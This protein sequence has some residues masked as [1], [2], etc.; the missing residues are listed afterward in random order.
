MRTALSLSSL[1]VTGCFLAP[2]HGNADEPQLTQEESS[3]EPHCVLSPEHWPIDSTPEFEGV[4]WQREVLEAPILVFGEIH[5]TRE[6][7]AFV[8]SYVA[9]YQE[10]GRSLVLAL[11]LPYED[12]NLVST[13]AAARDE[14]QRRTAI[15]SL[16]SSAAWTSEFQDGRTSEAMLQLIV[17]TA[18]IPSI[19][20]ERSSVDI[21]LFSVRGAHDREAEMAAIL[22]NLRRAQPEGQI[23]VLVGNLHAS[24]TPTPYSAGALP[25]A[26]RLE[27]VEPVLAL[28]FLSSTP[29]STWVCTDLGCGPRLVGSAR[30]P[31]PNPGVTLFQERSGGFDGTFAVGSVSPSEPA[32]HTLCIHD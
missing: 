5:G 18:S 31:E 30:L 25:L 22:S 2:R 20:Q 12:Q 10:T 8:S 27:S 9:A 28:N 23:V 3:I 14:T 15:E 11:E 16:L 7:P 4:E 17:E 6:I 32:A 29:G 13:L 26:G 19:R 1:L 21:V 24:T